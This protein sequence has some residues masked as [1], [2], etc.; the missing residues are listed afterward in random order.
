MTT[1]ANTQKE[2]FPSALAAPGRSPEIPEAADAYGWLIG[3][4][5]LDVCHFFVDVRARQIKG[6][7][8][9]A[10]VMEGRAVQDIWIMPRRTERGGE[11][12]R[13]LNMYGTTLR[14]WDADIQAWRVTWIDPVTGKRNELIGSRSC[15]DVVQVGRRTDGTTIRWI[16]SDITPDSFRWTGESLQPDGQT[17]KL[18][19][20]FR[21]RRI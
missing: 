2:D 15:N 9:F 14:V 20:E 4:W 1:A 11:V 5:E 8:H 19:A 3:S 7:V 21:A 16:F 6:E 10:W 12:D 18:D 17:W 13:K